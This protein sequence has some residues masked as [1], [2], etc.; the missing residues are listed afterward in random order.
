M[1][2]SIYEMREFGVPVPKRLL[3]SKSRW[4]GHLEIKERSDDGLHRTVVTAR[5][6][7][8]DR[9]YL[10]LE[11]Y[12]PMFVWMNDD[13]M[14]IKG[15]DRRRVGENMVEYAQSWL[16]LLGDHRLDEPAADAHAPYSYNKR[17]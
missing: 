4:V 17:R 16:C 15:F 7:R 3:A 14:V 13:R 9:T 8:Q 12:E 10:A 5:L 1:L 2:M 11:L 6:W